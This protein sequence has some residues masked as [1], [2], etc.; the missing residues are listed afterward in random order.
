MSHKSRDK[1]GCRQ[2]RILAVGLILLLLTACAAPSYY[3]QA[4]KGHLDLMGQRI[5]IDEILVAGT[6]DPH[7]TRQLALSVAIRE[8]AVTQLQL[9]D[10]DS[11]TQFVQTGQD[12]VTWNV[13]AAPEFSLTPKQWCFPV[14]GC[15]PYRGYFKQDKA[16]EFA[17]KLARKGFDTSISPAIAYS[18]LGWFDDP[19]L[20]TMFQYSDAQLA[21]YI[22]HELAHQKLYVKGDTAF[23]ES[24]ASFIEE[25]GVT[26][27]LESTQHVNEL[28]EWLDQKRAGFQYDEL[29][30]ETQMKLERL[31]ASTQAESTMREEKSAIFENL[32]NQY[33]HLVETEWDGR[34]Y[35]GRM[36]PGEM[37]NARLALV[38]RYRGGICAF[39]KIYSAAGQDM[40][41]FQQLA[42]SRAGLDKIQRMKWLQQPCDNI[43]SGSNL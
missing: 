35:R 32:R 25:T 14:S 20:D 9:P 8:F 29:L 18:T 7:L 3:S 19:L 40:T 16:V 6:A 23:N 42:T 31:Y 17:G 41:R 33:Q 15:V 10:N 34:Y 26:L 27:W 38:N 43:A 12:A 37:N 4:V 36:P 39:E 13:V 2:W 28:A 24:Y 22:F 30:R 21:A 5:D 1:K 11:Y